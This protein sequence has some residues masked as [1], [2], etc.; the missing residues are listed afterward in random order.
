MAFIAQI[1]PETPT[2]QRHYMESPTSNFTKLSKTYGMSFTALG[3]IRNGFHKNQPFSMKFCKQ[4]VLCMLENSITRLFADSVFQT[5][6][7]GFHNR[8]LFLLR[9]EHLTNNSCY[10]VE[11][12][13]TDTAGEFK[14]C[15]L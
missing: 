9:K 1:F 11:P 8:H 13:I 5:D 2:V 15:P 4:H 14:F 6:G 7:R 3:V 10:T 12:L